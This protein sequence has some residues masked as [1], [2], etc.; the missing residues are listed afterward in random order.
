LLCDYS[1]IVTLL[2][3]GLYALGTETRRSG[4]FARGFSRTLVVAAGAVPPIAALL[5]YQAWAFGHP[6]YPAQHYMPATEFS[7]AGWSGM[8]LPALDLLLQN[9]FDLRFGLFAFCPLLALA[10]V[11]P[12]LSPRRVRVAGPALLMLG[13]GYFVA[14]LLFSSANQFARLQWNSGVRYM[15]PAI[16]LLFLPVADVLLRLPR[17][18]ALMLGLFSVAQ[19]AALAMVREDVPMSLITLFSSGLRLPALTVLGNMRG[20]Y[21]DTLAASAPDPLPLF[22]LTFALLGVLWWPWRGVRRRART[23][24]TAGD[25]DSTRARAARRST[26]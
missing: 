13:V 26:R 17:Q 15:V 1:G 4:S 23:E 6:L 9:L 16:P 3:I 8:S 14:L 19:A 12:L 18:L 7:V 5:G 21:I 2:A 25:V 20:Q 24:K 10:F 22:W 11:A